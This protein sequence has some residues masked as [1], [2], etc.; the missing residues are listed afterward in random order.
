[1][2]NLRKIIHLNLISVNNQTSSPFEHQF[3]KNT[4]FATYSSN[5]NAIAA[6]G[7]LNSRPS[8]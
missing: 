1:M 6:I 3:S 2:A 8:E 7:G 4:L 5:L